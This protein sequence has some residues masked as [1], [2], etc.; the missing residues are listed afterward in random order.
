MDTPTLKPLLSGIT[1]YRAV[2]DAMTAEMQRRFEVLAPRGTN[3]KL[4]VEARIQDADFDAYNEA[5]IWFTGAPLIR[6]G[7][8]SPGGMVTVAGEGYY[9]AVGA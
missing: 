9:L 7:T 4:P 6:A 3:W 8:V 1:S 5:V 2:T